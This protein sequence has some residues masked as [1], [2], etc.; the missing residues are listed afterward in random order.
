MRKPMI[1]GALIA[2]VALMSALFESV[3][4][5]EDAPATTTQEQIAVLQAERIKTLQRAV[6]VLQGMYESGVVDI[7]RLFAA[8]NDLI[9]AQLE[10]ATEKAERLLL[11]NEHL[12]LARAE[13]EAARI[14]FRSGAGSE[15][16]YLR[17]VATRLQREISLLQEK[18]IPGISLE[19]RGRDR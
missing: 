9:E 3:V 5:D 2:M 16:D 14:R 10:L 13:E 11:F 19:E 7:T 12:Q 8:R 1:G 17:A 15:A 6:K 4:G 18:S